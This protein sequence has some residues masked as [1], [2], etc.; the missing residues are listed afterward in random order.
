MQEKERIMTE[1]I[2]LRQGCRILLPSQ[3]KRLLDEL[4]PGYQI[5]CNALWNTGLRVVEFWALCDNPHWYHASS[6]LIDLP[7]EGSAK[8][9][10]C[11]VKERTIK[12]TEAGCKSLEVLFAVKPH[13]KERDAMRGALKRA[14]IRAGLGDKG[15]MPK[16]FRKWLASYLVECRKDLGIDTLEICANMGHDEKTLRKYYYGVFSTTDHAEVLE[17]VKGLNG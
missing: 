9:V 4:D 16:M 10:K 15:V 12:L 6:R 5:I 13:F 14:A 1:R 8:K 7:E 11:E 3:G 17:F 2:I